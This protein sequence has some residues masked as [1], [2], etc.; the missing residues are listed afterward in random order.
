MLVH[1][2]YFSLKDSSPAAVEKLLAASRKYLVDH[3]GVTFFACGTPCD[4]DRPV[5]VR[6]WEVGLH[7]AFTDRAAH[8]RYQ[9]A[10]RHLQFIA[11]CKE[12]WRQVRVFDS[13]C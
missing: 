13:D 1:N 12:N 5:N 2:V 7:V 9:E 4:L 10:E 11:E 8:D 3:P 6:D